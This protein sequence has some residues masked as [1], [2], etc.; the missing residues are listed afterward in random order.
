[1]SG[2]NPVE[3]VVAAAGNQSNLAS[4]L[5]VTQQAVSKWLRR[6]WVPLARAAE[7]EH[8]FGIPRKQLI[9]PRLV[10]LLDVNAAN[11]FGN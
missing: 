4:S 7:I 8:L 6:G 11:D 3:A 10:D 5:G 2:S 9:N 1:M